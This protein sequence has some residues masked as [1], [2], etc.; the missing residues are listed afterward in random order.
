MKAGDL[1]SDLSDPVATG[2]TDFTRERLNAL[3]RREDRAEAERILAEELTPVL[4]EGTPHE[5]RRFHCCA[6]RMSGGDLTRLRES[7]EVARMDFRDLLSNGDFNRPP[8]LHGWKPRY[9]DVAMAEGWLR[10]SRLPD[11]DFA[12]E[13]EVEVTVAGRRLRVAAVQAL[14]ALEPTVRYCVVLT[15]GETWDVSQEDLRHV[16]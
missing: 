3:F 7:V 16:D 13:D 8:Y 9:F 10:G 5:N 2:I 12:P 11:V 1:G 14:I 15:T 6:L 4:P